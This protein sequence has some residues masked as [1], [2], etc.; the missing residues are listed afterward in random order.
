MTVFDKIKNLHLLLI[1]DDEWI[2][3]SMRLF[4]EG[5]GCDLVTLETAEQAIELIKDHLFDVIIADYRL[6]GING[7][8]FFKQTAKLNQSSLKILI[9]AYMN[10]AVVADAKTAGVHDLIEKPFNPE[11][12]EKSL[13]KLLGYSSQQ[14]SNT[15]Q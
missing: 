3:D 12:I 9:T 8:E 7:I 1:D 13:S 15:I 14:Q 10:K 6:P 4:F 11:T 2:R 5:E